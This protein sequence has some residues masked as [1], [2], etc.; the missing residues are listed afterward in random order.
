MLLAV[1]LV[2]FVVGSSGGFL[3][4][5]LVKR[6]EQELPLGGIARHPA[7]QEIVIPVD[8]AFRKTRVCPPN[9]YEAVISDDVIQ[10][11]FRGNVGRYSLT[12]LF[13]PQW[14]IPRASITEVSESTNRF[15]SLKKRAP[16]IELTYLGSGGKVKS[17]A[18]ASPN[19]EVL[20]KAV[21]E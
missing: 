16:S 1:I 15:F 2:L 19:I 10:I 3:S 17:L 11:A 9:T 13:F 5:F 4:F 14:N 18:I 12:R 20:W 21:G 8:V 6:S 7:E